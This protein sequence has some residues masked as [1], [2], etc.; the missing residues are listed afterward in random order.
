[1]QP[2]KSVTMTL[3]STDNLSHYD[4]EQEQD[5]ID[6]DNDVDNDI[7]IDNDVDNDIDNDFDND[8]DNDVDNDND[9]DIIYDDNNDDKEEVDEQDVKNCIDDMFLNTPA[10]V[11]NANSK[12]TT[13]YDT[14]ELPEIAFD[15]TDPI[16]LV[17]NELMEDTHDKQS[18]DKHDVP[19]K[20]IVEL[21][22]AAVSDL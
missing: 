15:Q 3:K 9:D 4:V 1:M 21:V 17:V 8:V 20:S 5:D 13:T 10:P 12:P 2:S 16:L 18:D 14:M 11:A 22:S 6:I 7:D 19:S